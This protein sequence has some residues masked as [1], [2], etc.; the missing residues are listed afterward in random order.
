MIASASTASLSDP[1]TRAQPSGRV[2]TRRS[3]R[4]RVVVVRHVASSSPS[5]SCVKIQDAGAS[6]WAK[7]RGGVPSE[8]ASARL[9]SPRQT[10][11]VAQRLMARSAPR[12]R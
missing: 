10:C 9:L 5:A 3:P 4:G 8:K 11:S 1:G 6:G 2:G 7:A 12:A